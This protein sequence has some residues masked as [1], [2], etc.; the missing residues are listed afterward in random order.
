VSQ[1]NEANPRLTFVL[2]EHCEMIVYRE[3]QCN[4]ANPRLTF[5][6]VSGIC[7][8]AVCETLT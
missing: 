8:Y 1:Y 6:I 3:K 7:M 5:T 2:I 4:E